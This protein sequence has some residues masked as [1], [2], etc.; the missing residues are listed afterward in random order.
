M[1][2]V[3]DLI[4]EVVSNAI[5]AMK[6]TDFFYGISIWAMCQL[7]LGLFFL[8]MILSTIFGHKGDEKE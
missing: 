8:E 4:F 3:W 1:T 5:Q 6:D 7:F 2:S